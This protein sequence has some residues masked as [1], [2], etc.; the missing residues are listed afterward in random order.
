MFALGTSWEE[1]LYAMMDDTQRL[2]IAMAQ[3]LLDFLEARP[4]TRE[5]VSRH[6]RDNIASEPGTKHPVQSMLRKIGVPPPS[7]KYLDEGLLFEI[8]NYKREILMTLLRKSIELQEP[9]SI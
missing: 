5:I 1:T 6:Y 4:F 2:P 3:E 7:T 9:L 8:L